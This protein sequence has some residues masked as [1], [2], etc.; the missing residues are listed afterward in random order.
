M[1]HL[2]SKLGIILAVI[3]ITGSV[4]ATPLSGVWDGWTQFADG[5]ETSSTNTNTA[6]GPGYGGQLFDAEYLFYKLDTV[7][8]T[9]SVG[10]QAGFNL[11]TGTV[12]VGGHPYYAGDLA[13]SFDGNTSNYEYAVDFGLLTKDYN[14]NKV[15]AGTGTGIDGAGLYSVSAW[16]NGVYG[17]FTVSN[18]FAMDAGS[19]VAGINNASGSGTADGVTSY[20]RQVT[21][22][23]SGLGLGDSYQVDAHWTMSCGNDNINGSFN[24]QEPSTL[25]LLGLGL[26]GLGLVRMRKVKA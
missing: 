1:K 4:Q 16:N 24:V 2:I 8:N 20:Y 9:L 13:L 15:D 14:L 10:L 17:G 26:L 21:F 19:L 5:E 18:P 12:T 3:M 7:N 25:F 22:D 11:V 6:V 23:L